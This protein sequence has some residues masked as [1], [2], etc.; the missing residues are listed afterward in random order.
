[1]KK[2]LL[3]TA[4]VSLLLFAGCQKNGV[5]PKQDSVS[6]KKSITNQSLNKSKDTIMVGGATTNTLLRDTIMVTNK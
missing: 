3:L 1:M 5:A 6:A 4:S 2:A